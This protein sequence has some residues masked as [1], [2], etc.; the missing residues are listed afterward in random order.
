MKSLFILS[1]LLMLI[2]FK[3]TPQTFSGEFSEN[4]PSLSWVF[5]TRQPFYASPFIHDDVIYIGGTD[6]IFRA[7]NLHNGHEIWQYACGGQ[8]RSTACLNGGNIIF[9][10][11]TGELICLK[12]DGSLQWKFN[13]GYETPYDFADYHQSSPVLSDGIIYWGSGSGIFYALKADSG[14][15]VWKFETGSHVHTT[16]AIDQESVYFG[17]F[18]GYVY[19]LNLMDGSLRWKFKTVGHQ[20]FPKGEVQGS[21]VIIGNQVIIGARDYNLY[22]LD[23]EKGYCHWNKVYTLGWVLSASFYDSTLFIAGADERILAAI[24]PWTEV[25]SGKTRWSCSCL[26]SRLFRMKPF[27]S[28]RPSENCMRWIFVPGRKYGCS[29]RHLMRKTVSGISSPMIPIVMIFIQLS[30]PIYTF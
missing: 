3:G 10:N 7:I 5:S 2:P 23:K 30:H 21:P 18:N 14:E 12:T 4:E 6:S 17:S 15:L 25:T 29:I 27:L 9:C 11:G 28:E 1:I 19:A 26:A 8:I 16:A 20:Y 24:N 13:G 22:A